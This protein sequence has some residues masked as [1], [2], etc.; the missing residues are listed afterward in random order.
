MSLLARSRAHVSYVQSIPSS[1]SSSSSLHDNTYV[2]YEIRV[3]A[4]CVSVDCGP[5]RNWASTTREHGYAP[6]ITG[7]DSSPWN[8]P[9]RSSSVRDTGRPKGT[10][11]YGHG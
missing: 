2:G 4:D 11:R 6:I 10:L 9:P 8:R 1:L 7:S 5:V 3:H